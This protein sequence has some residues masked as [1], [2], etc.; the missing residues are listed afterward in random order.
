MNMKNTIIMKLYRLAWFKKAAIKYLM[1]N[2]FYFRHI[3]YCPCCNQEVYFESRSS[4][5]RD[6]FI[7]NNCNSI[8]RERALMVVIEKH[9]PNWKNLDIH[10]SSPGFRGGKFKIKE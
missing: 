3:G 6:Y 10:E 7:C 4:W 9:Y 5:L 8:P 1:P 2:G